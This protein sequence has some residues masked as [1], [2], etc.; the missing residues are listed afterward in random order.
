MAE[1]GEGTSEPDMI[2]RTDVALKQQSWP[3]EPCTSFRARRLPEVPY[4]IV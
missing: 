4:L 2:A 3:K 1:L